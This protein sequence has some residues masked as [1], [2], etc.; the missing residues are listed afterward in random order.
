MHEM[1]IDAFSSCNV[2]NGELPKTL[3]PFIFP[4]SFHAYGQQ[5]WEK[6]VDGG[7]PFLPKSDP[8]KA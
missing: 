6:N 8:I 4:V 1:K 7:K 5:L 2:E 3:Y